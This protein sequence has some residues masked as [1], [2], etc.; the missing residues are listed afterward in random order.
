MTKNWVSKPRRSPQEVRTMVEE[1]KK[2]GQTEKPSPEP[3]IE[4]KKRID[5]S[6]RVARFC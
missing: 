4:S 5:L 1:R 6:R 3:F 2:K